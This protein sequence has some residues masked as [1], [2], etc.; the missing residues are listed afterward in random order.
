MS[1]ICKGSL[2]TWYQMKFQNKQSEWGM[3]STENGTKSECHEE[4]SA[5]NLCEIGGYDERLQLTD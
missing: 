2:P 3:K 1:I 5:G 4:V